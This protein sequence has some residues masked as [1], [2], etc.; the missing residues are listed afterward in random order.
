MLSFDCCNEIS[1]PFLR[2]PSRRD[3]KFLMTFIIPQSILYWTCW[4]RLRWLQQKSNMSIRMTPARESSI[5]MHDS[6]RSQVCQNVWVL[7]ESSMSICITPAGVNYIFAWLLQESS[8]SDWMTAAGVKYVTMNDSC[9][10]RVFQC[11]TPTRVKFVSMHDSCRSQIFHWR[12]PAG[13]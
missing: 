5:S 7:Q 13:V 1:D 8:M 11:M 3:L 9:R 4:R 2:C 6:C 12:T 10:S